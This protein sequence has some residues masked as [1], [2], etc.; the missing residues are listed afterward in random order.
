MIKH[1]I[2][3][4]GSAY[5]EITAIVMRDALGLGVDQ[6][7]VYDDKWLTEQ[8]F[9]ATPEFQYLFTHQGVG[10][11]SGRRGFGW[12]CW[13]PFVIRHALDTYCADGDIVM[14]I[15]ADTYPAVVR[16]YDVVRVAGAGGQ[17]SG[18][19]LVSRASPVNSDAAFRTRLGLRRNARSS[20]SGAGGGI[21]GGIL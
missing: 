2:T 6:I 1:L 17:L 5:D 19:W 3:F 16:A 9:F 4:G 13:K 15:D 21:P 20:G 11:P 10:N 14:F 7:H 18:D 8:P 12:F